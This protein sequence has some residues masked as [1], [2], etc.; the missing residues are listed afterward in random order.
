[1]GHDRDGHLDSTSHPWLTQPVRFYGLLDREHAE[2]IEF[3]ATGR[4]AD[5]E[6]AEILADEPDWSGK[7][8]IVIV[9]FGGLEPTVAS[10][11]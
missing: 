3:Y 9:D 7:L 2:V 1:M 6:L 8:E 10:A 4:D 11:G 5:R